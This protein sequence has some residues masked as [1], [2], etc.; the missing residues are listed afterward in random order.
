M[1]FSGA[2]L[3][4]ISTEGYTSSSAD[5]AHLTE[6]TRDRMLEA[7]ED[8]GRKRQEQL[9]LAG[10]GQGQGQGEREA[11]LAGREST[12]GETASARIEAPS[13]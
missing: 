11:L 10:H 7:I 2:V 1:S 3:E 12:S 5:I 9:R 8:L 4:P 13:E 6:L